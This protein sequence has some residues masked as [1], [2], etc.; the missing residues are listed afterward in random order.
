VAV[1]SESIV[2]EAL[3]DWFGNLGYEVVNGADIA[4]GEPGA[5]RDDYREV[6]LFGR[7]DAALRELNPGVP[8]AALEEAIRVLTR[9]TRPALVQQNREFHRQLV[10]GISVE[11]PDHDG[12]VRGY[13]VKLIDSE[14]PPNNDWL[15]VNQF[16]VLDRSLRRPDVLVFVNGIPIGHVE[17]KNPR[18]EEADILSA[19]HQ[20]KTYGQEIP[21][22]LR[23]NEVMVVSDGNEA[24]VGS[25]TSLWEWFMRWRTVEGT[26]VAPP[27]A[28]ELE[29]LI[30]GI[31]D[32][33]RFLDLVRYFIVFE[34]DDGVLTKKIAGYHQFHAARKTVTTTLAAASEEGDGRGGVIWHTQGSGKSLTMAFFAGKLIAEPVLANPTIVVLTDRLDLD[35]QLF[36]VFSRC[37][38]LLRQTPKQADSRAELRQ[39]LTRAG[40]GVVFT[41]IQKFMPEQRGDRY[42]MLSDR[43]NIV[44]IADEA[45]RSQYDFID[46]FARHMRDAL[47]NA[48]FVGFTGTP[49]ELDDRDTR[50]VFGDYVDRYDIRRAVE[51]EA[52]VPIYYESRLAK[53]DLPKEARPRLDVGFEEVTEG[54][55]EARKERLKT[56]WAQL[57]GVVGTSK[58]LAQVAEDLVTHWE[59]RLEAM[60]GKAMVV[61]MSRRICVDLYAEIAKLRPEWHSDDDAAGVMKVVMTGSN[62]DPVAW[63]SHIRNK[64]RREALARRFRD[65]EDPFKFVIVRDMWLTGFDA[66]SLTTM[67]VDKPMRG[68]ALMQA[69]ARVNRVFKDKPGGLVVDYLGIAD[70]LR[71]ALAIYSDSGGEGKPTVDQDEAVAIMLERVEICE[72][73]FHGFDYSDFIDGTATERL[74][75]LPEAQEHV[76]AQENGRERF[77]Q[78]V[79]ELSKAF[80]LSVPRQEALD[81]RD[82][83]AFFQTVKAALVKT[84]RRRYTPEEELEHAIRQVVSG[85]ITP[86]GVIDIF[87][88]AGLPKPDI[89]LLSEEFLAEVR[90]MPQR[91]LAVELL[92]RLLNDEIKTRQKKNIVQSRQFS[93]LLADALS[94]YQARAITTAQVI[95][96]LIDLA[97]DMREA[98]SRGEE[99]GLT[100]EEVAFYDALGTNDSAVAVL[101][102]ETLRTIARELAE[103]VKK[104]ATI[105][106]TQKE[107]VRAAMRVAVKRTLRRHGYPPD[108][109]E[110]ATALVLEQA[111]QLGLELAV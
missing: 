44:V 75:V 66:P 1:I 70:D 3:L 87:E 26:D 9:T 27:T 91:N 5:E 93:E 96:E 102:D 10:W 84:D 83:V 39:L 52:T 46:G 105:D 38:D 56:K 110:K 48:T 69:I 32:R 76:L 109:Q 101:G 18:D 49:L 34:D 35:G 107:S 50:A 98:T 94:K 79:T 7:L 61:C 29:V 55:E 71:K 89:S 40:G 74:A 11:A 45:H 37:S 68:H 92:Q 65:P 80:A 95:E 85:A 17:L 33:S 58:R 111:E 63:Q 42:P 15:V 99:L 51:D 53:L 67:Y 57:E 104:N 86:G 54:E 22:L 108:K 59:G 73:I 72:D 82:Q 88:A 21:S 23:F 62:T 2:E 20:L 97:R 36:G 4:P 47:P 6:L 78:G 25:L 24:R 103:T 60:D 106:W 100:D 90:D 77:V 30:R 19:F 31:F 12:S 13:L 28:N 43:R 14:N 41:T 16:S 64:P 81:V 8:H